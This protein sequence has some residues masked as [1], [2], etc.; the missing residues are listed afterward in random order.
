MRGTAP[1][2]VRS[3]SRIDEVAA[4]VSMARICSGVHYRNSTEVGVAMGRKVGE[5][6]VAAQRRVAEAR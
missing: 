3:W 6:A 1:G 5:V 2:V 4:E